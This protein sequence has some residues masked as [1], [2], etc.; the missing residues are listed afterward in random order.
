MQK[1]T[2]EL[3]T[4]LRGQLDRLAGFAPVPWPV[5]SL[6]L[7]MRPDQH[8][9][10]EYATFV[11]KV[12]HERGRTL[13]GEARKSFERDGLRIRDYLEG[14][15]RVS[16]NGL[17]IFACAACRD[18]FEVL[19]L[20]APFEA[21]WL[22]IGAVPH[23]YPLARLN[24]QYPR[25]AALLLDTNAARLFVFSLGAVERERR[26]TH[27]KTRKT[28]VGAWSQARYQRHAENFHKH[29]IKEVVGVLDCVVRDE[30]L[31]RI[32]V[33]AGDEARPALM[34]ELPQHLAD[35]VVDI[36]AL[37]I[38]APEHRVL[39]ES[40]DALRRHDAHA[41]AAHV[42]VMLDQ[43]RRGGLAVVGPDDT[44]QALV[45]GQVEELLI[46]ALPARLR[47]ATGMPSDAPPGPVDVDTSAPSTDLDAERHRL[48]DELVTRAQRNG[49]RI[50]F[51]EDAELLA[52]VGGVGALLRFRI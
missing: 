14:E 11:R 24:D 39:A 28:S 1:T 29:H 38:R 6:Y 5:L 52:D 49:A 25:Y 23:L 48:A 22:F 32:V 42:E 45:R 17:A 51:V 27:V 20:D 18:F 9:R 13:K 35:K 36:L 47:R 8:G 30:G 34:H 21:H 4:P 44:L 15:R 16:A 33:A 41:D 37:D 19:Q 40:L 2:T 3:A 26:V 43:W 31:T 7:D 50:R 10:D 46:T 12:F